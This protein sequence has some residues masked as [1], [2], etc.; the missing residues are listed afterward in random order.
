MYAF[1]G[2]DRNQLPGFDDAA[3]A[4]ELLEQKHVLIAPGVS[5]NVDY[6]NHFRITLL[7]DRATLETVFARIEELLN[8]HVADLAM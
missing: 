2:V 8:I 3:F 7:P 1:V 6:N 5:F 4:L